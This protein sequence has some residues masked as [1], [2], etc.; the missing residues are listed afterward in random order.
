MTGKVLGRIFSEISKALWS[1]VTAAITSSTSVITRLRV[2]RIP[3]HSVSS[4]PL[5]LSS[6]RKK[7]P[8]VR[9]LYFRL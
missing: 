4:S 2:G 7:S 3:F 5:T 9:P 6:P 8:F 1:A